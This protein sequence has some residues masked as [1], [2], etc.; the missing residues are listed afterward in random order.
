[1]RVVYIDKD[2]DLWVFYE[3][4]IIAYLLEVGFSTKWKRIHK[5]FSQVETDYGPL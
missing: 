4:G 2:N 3:G 5:T 1:M